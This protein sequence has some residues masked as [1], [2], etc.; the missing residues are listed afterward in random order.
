MATTLPSKEPNDENLV[1]AELGP[2]G[3]RTGPK[4]KPEE[5]NYATVKT[6]GL[7]YPPLQQSFREEP[8]KAFYEPPKYSV[9]SRGKKDPAEQPL[10]GDDGED[11][12]EDIVV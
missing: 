7:Y 1:Y 5:S 4:P 9:A 11:Y 10:A 2:G 12:I 8:K 3:G 6:E